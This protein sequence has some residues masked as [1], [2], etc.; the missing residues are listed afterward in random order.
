MHSLA[1]DYV[2]VREVSASD[3]V[4][5]SIAMSPKSRALSKAVLDTDPPCSALHLFPPSTR[6]PYV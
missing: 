2:D 3:A 1:I 6:S 5:V 4:V